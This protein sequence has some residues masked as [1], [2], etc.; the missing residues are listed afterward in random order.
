[1]L[2]LIGLGLGEGD[3]PMKALEALKKCDSIY[4][5]FYTSVWQGD[6]DRLGKDIGKRI[7]ILPREKVESDFLIN[8]AKNKD[9]ALLVAGDPLTAT[10]HM[11]ILI[12]ARQNKIKTEVIHASSI[13]TAIGETGLQLYKFGRATTLAMPEKNYFPE[14]PY[15]II[16]ENK[17]SGLHT[18]VL[19]DIPMTAKQGMEVLLELEKRKKK[20]IIGDKI[21]A[22]CRLGSKD[23]SI[24]YGDINALINDKDLGPIPA[25]LLIPGML[26]FKEEE[27]LELW[28][29]N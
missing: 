22:C 16:A 25:V 2:C 3:M 20:G 24:K 19:L 29:K 13:Y 8:E 6:I 10:T 21:V 9:V 7:E 4:A 17:K 15:D 27:A 14:S 1:M 26:N 23:K 28:K 18:L 5:E 11:Q 12:D